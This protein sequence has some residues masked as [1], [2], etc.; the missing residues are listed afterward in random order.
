VLGIAPSTPGARTGS[1]PVLTVFMIGWVKAGKAGKG[2]EGG[3]SLIVGI[4]DSLAG[5]QVGVRRS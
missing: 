3:D 1:E 4:P 5:P 2:G